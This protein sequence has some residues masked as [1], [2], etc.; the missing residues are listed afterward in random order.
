M[1]DLT[2][3]ADPAEL[4]RAMS[5]LLINAVQHTPPGTPVTV[6][7]SRRAD[8]RPTVSVI[9]GG[10]GIPEAELDRVF[11]AGWRGTAARSPIDGAR[12]GGAG[13]GLAIVAGILKAHNG[14]ATVRNVPGGCRF[15]LILPA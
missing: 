13:L 14:E 2:V 4:S 6:I 9:D 11:D 10:G 5:N 1:D 15:D 3:R 8:G 12:S 7:A